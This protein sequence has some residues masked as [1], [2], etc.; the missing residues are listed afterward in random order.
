MSRQVGIGHIRPVDTLTELRRSDKS[1]AAPHVK[2]SLM[3][4][5][6]KY[7]WLLPG[8]WVLIG[9]K[10]GFACLVSSWPGGLAGK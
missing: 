5:A 6:Y 4:E 7:Y 2:F 8:A 9:T 10:T 3:A 1:N